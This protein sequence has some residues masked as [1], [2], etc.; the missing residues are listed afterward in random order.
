MYSDDDGFI[1]VSGSGFGFVDMP[2]YNSW[3]A[4]DYTTSVIDEKVTF[5][6]PNLASTTGDEI[7]AGSLY[8]FNDGTTPLP[9]EKIKYYLTRVAIN[10]FNFTG[11]RSA[12]TL[13][14]FPIEIAFDPSLITSLADLEAL[15]SFNITS[16]YDWNLRV[17]NGS[18]SGQNP[19]SLLPVDFFN[20]SQFTGNIY[21]VAIMLRHFTGSFTAIDSEIEVSGES[22]KVLTG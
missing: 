15:V 9:F 12:T 17:D 22:I 20:T 2:Y 8:L 13:A 21:G 10:K 4:F 6:C 18:T 11:D 7:V 19:T 5:T 14:I 3:A 16:I 1:E